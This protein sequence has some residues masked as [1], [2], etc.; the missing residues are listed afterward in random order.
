MAAVDADGAANVAADE[1][2]LFG[3]GTADGIVH[4]TIRYGDA[5]SR[6][7]CWRPPIWYS[8]S[9]AGIG[10]DVVAT[11]QIVVSAWT[12]DSDSDGPGFVAVA[13]NEVTW[14]A[15][16]TAGCGIAPADGVVLGLTP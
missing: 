5:E 15:A 6:S 8:Y 4:G 12:N 1:I 2:A 10:P 14:T 9:A 16:C 11:D 13:T 3:R 7:S